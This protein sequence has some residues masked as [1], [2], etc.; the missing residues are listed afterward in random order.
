MRDYVGLDGKFYFFALV[1]KEYN[2]SMS[3][4]EFLLLRP[5]GKEM[6]DRKGW[7]MRKDG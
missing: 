3:Q 6:D 4:G 1:R 2:N 7:V 5:Q